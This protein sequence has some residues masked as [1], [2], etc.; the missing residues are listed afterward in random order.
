MRVSG[1]QD[2]DGL[3]VSTGKTTAVNENPATV[4]AHPSF[5]INREPIWHI[6]HL[7]AL[8]NFFIKLHFAQVFTLTG[9][10]IKHSKSADSQ[11]IR[12]SKVSYWQPIEAALSP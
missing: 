11:F 1:A 12:T 7:E 2:R 10:R 6:D 5:Q 3:V 9:L 8:L 4:L